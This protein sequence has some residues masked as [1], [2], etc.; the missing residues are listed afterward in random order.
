[1]SDTN[2]IPGKDNGNPSSLT[3][4]SVEVFALSPQ[5]SSSLRS[6]PPGAIH[7]FTERLANL[8]HYAW[9]VI[10]DRQSPAIYFLLGI[11]LLLIL[12]SPLRWTILF[13]LTCLVSGYALASPSIPSHPHYQ[14]S[15]L[16]LFSTPLPNV[17]HAARPER[18]T[19]VS[20][21]SLS[22]SLQAKITLILDY[23][24]RDF[25]D[26]WYDTLNQSGYREFQSTVRSSLL[27]AMDSLLSLA[28][29]NK[30]PESVDLLSLVI[31]GLTNA[32]I[33]HMKEFREFESVSP[34]Y[35]SLEAFIEG[36]S[37]SP[38]W[39]GFHTSHQAE[40]DH[41]HHVA[42]LLLSR[43]L[44]PEDAASPPLFS[45]LKELIAGQFLW[46]LLD[47]LSEPDTL[48]SFLLRWLKP[49]FESAAKEESSSLMSIKL[50]ITQ[51][52]NIPF[53]SSAEFYLVFGIDGVKKKTR[54]LNLY[55]SSN[56]T[57]PLFLQV[58]IVKM[59]PQATTAMVLTLFFLFSLSS[60]CFD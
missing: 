16:P 29:A 23:F 44:P 28:R 31:Y 32:V 22:P 17:S 51:I 45:L 37:D 39:K 30:G 5:E 14:R 15:F 53:L 46:P 9:R 60:D 6:N 34:Q 7:S 35:A 19:T 42:A 40:L 3:L 11:F 50:K 10:Q 27:S 18:K 38:Y 12:T 56:K 26:Y 21:T 20:V 13:S 43:L 59:H 47:R 55:S 36:H 8:L 49:P 33:L 52:Q 4:D 57:E 2:S 58:E 48:N 41:L 25:I 54:L 24:I 1:M